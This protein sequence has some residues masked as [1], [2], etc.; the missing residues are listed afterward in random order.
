MARGGTWAQ[1]SCTDAASLSKFPASLVCFSVTAQGVCL[2]S[3]FFLSI[4]L[5]K[6]SQVPQVLSF[7]LSLLMWLFPWSLLVASPSVLLSIPLWAKIYNPLGHLQEP[8]W[9]PSHFKHWVVLQK[10]R[11]KPLRD[12]NLSFRAN[13]FYFLFFLCEKRKNLSL[14]QT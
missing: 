13:I 1:D 3:P 4:F 9:C 8:C 14:P 11:G 2:W 7:S 5:D 6:I 10:I 12:P